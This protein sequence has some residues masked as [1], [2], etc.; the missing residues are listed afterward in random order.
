MPG[1]IVQVRRDNGYWN[2][3]G[4]GVARPNDCVEPAGYVDVN[5]PNYRTNDFYGQYRRSDGRLDKYV[6]E[7]V[8][9]D[10]TIYHRDEP[11]RNVLRFMF[12]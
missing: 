9:G 10:P 5:N 1:G 2:G 11:L 6:S 8:Y 7:N 4:Q 3:Y 12:P